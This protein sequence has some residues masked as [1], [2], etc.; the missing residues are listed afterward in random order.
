MSIHMK[1]DLE[2]L[3]RDLL[4]MCAMVEEMIHQAADQLSNP[5]F[6]QARELDARDND[7]DAREIALEEECLKILALHQP[8]AV[9]LRR[10]TS[11]PKISGELERV[12]DLA[13]HVAERACGLIPSPQIEV[14]PKLTQMVEHAV[15]MLHQSIDAYV[16]LDCELARAVCENDNVVDDLNREIIDALLRSMRAAPESVE[17]L[18]HLFSASRHIERVADH[19]TNIAEDVVYLVEGEIIRHQSPFL[20]DRRRVSGPHHV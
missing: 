5:D 10:I 14:P 3:H 9:D 16:A 6:E 2:K 17:P 18:M 11:V 8:V 20:D 15:T 4:S 19:A 7:I 12:A 13:V 1:R